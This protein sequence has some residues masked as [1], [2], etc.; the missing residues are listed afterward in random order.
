MATMCW[1]RNC[2]MQGPTQKAAK[3][4][5]ETAL[6]VCAAN[7]KADSVERLLAKGADM[8][9]VDLSKGQNALMWAA[10]EGR[11]AVVK[12]L[13]A[14]GAGRECCLERGISLRLCSLRRKATLRR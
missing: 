2:S 4:N 14:R 6:M 9:A 10:A 11:P 3:L 5:G 1:F 13:T 12:V 7:G 8:K